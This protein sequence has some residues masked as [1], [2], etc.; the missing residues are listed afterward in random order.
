MVRQ[1]AGDIKHSWEMVGDED[2][3]E[4]LG[5]AEVAGGSYYACMNFFQEKPVEEVPAEEEKVKGEVPMKEDINPGV[6]LSMDPIVTN[7]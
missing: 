5:T 3:L 7:F 2:I 6:I 1:L 4:E